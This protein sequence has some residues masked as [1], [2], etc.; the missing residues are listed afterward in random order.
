LKH[1]LQDAL[2]ELKTNTSNE[3]GFEK[4]VLQSDQV[5]A[6]IKTMNEDDAIFI[7]VPIPKECIIHDYIVMF[8]V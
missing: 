6:Q 1:H 3:E 8:H 7:Y 5:L 4:V 2:K